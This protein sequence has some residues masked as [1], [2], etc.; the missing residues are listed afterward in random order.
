MPFVA[1][2]ETVLSL[3]GRFD[4]EA[5][6]EVF[7]SELDDLLDF[8]LYRWKDGEYADK[9]RQQINPVPIV[10]GK[11]LS[12]LTVRANEKFSL[13]LEGTGLWLVRAQA[14]GL[15]AYAFVVRNNLGALAVEAGR[16]TLVWVQNLTD[17]RRA[18]NKRVR[19]YSLADERKIISEGRTGSD[20]AIKIPIDERADIA[21][22]GE[23]DDPAIVPLNLRNLNNNYWNWSEDFGSVPQKTLQF[24]FTDRPLYKPGDTVFFKAIVRTDDDTIYRVQ[25]G[26][27]WKAVLA[28]G[29]GE[30]KK[31]Y[32]QS[33][34]T[35]DEFGNF[36]GEFVIPADAPTG[37]Y[38]LETERETQGDSQRG[39]WFWRGGGTVYFRVEHYRKPEQTVKV[40]WGKKTAVAGQSAQIHLSGRYFSGQ[41]LA[42]ERVSYR[43]T[44]S[45]VYDPDRYEDFLHRYDNR[46]S[47]YRGGW[48]EKEVVSGE[49]VLGPDGTATVDIPVGAAVEGK[50]SLYT[51]EVNH[52]PARGEPVRDWEN[53]LVFPQKY[54]LYRTDDNFSVEVGEKV[55]LKLKL[56]PFVPGVDLSGRKFVV[57]PE[58]VW[59]ERNKT[60]SGIYDYTRREEKL[61]SFEVVSDKRGELNF[62]FSAEKEGS[63]TFSVENNDDRGFLSKDFYFWIYQTDDSGIIERG[64]LSILPTKN[65]LSPHVA[66]TFVITSE[67]PVGDVLFTLERDYAHDYR[68]VSLRKK[69]TKVSVPIGDWAVPNFNAAVRGFDGKELNV[70][71]KNVDVVSSGKRLGIEVEGIKKIYRP[72][73]KVKLKLRVVD[74]AGQPQRADLTVW[75]VDKAIFELTNRPDRDIFDRFWRYRYGFTRFG[76]SL[77]GISVEMSEGGGCFAGETPILLSDGTRKPIKD[78]KVGDKV[79]SRTSDGRRVVRTVTAVSVD[80]EDGYLL[81]NDKLRVT[82]DHLLFVNGAWR[83]ADEVRLGDKLLGEDGRSVE[84]KSLSYHRQSLPVYN[85]KVDKDFNYFAGGILAHNGKG[86]TDVRSVFKDVAYWN[87]SVRTD[88]RGEATVEFVLPDNLTTWSLSMVGNTLDTKVGETIKDLTV[89]KEYILQPV[90]PNILRDGDKPV[91]AL[92]VRNFSEKDGEFAITLTAEGAAEKTDRKVVEISA[93]EEILLE[94]PLEIKSPEGGE[95]SLH[96]E[97]FDKS[98]KRLDGVKQIIP[99]KPL[100]WYEKIS[101]AGYGS[102]TEYKLD[103]PADV[104][105]KLSRISFT[106]SP[107][108]IGSLSGAAKYLIHYPYGCMEQTVS[109]FIPALL[110]K[111]YPQVFGP[112]LAGKDLDAMVR[113]GVER[114]RKHQNTD[115][116]WSWWSGS[117]D[118]FLSAYIGDYLVR[119]R[120]LGIDVGDSLDKLRGYLERGYLV[121]DASSYASEQERIERLAGL[122]IVRDQ[123]KRRKLPPIKVSTDLPLETVA[124]AVIANVR[125]GYDDPARNGADVLGRMAQ[126]TGDS[127]SWVWSEKAR[128]NVRGD[129]SAFALRAFLLGGGERELAWRAVK[130]LRDERRREYWYNTFSTAQVLEAL[131]LFA[132]QEKESTSVAAELLDA[133]AERILQA[134]FAADASV[135]EIDLS[136]DTVRRGVSL[137]SASGKQVYGSLF[138]RLFRTDMSQA[139]LSQGLTL[140]RYYIKV[141]PQG[142]KVPETDGLRA[143]DTVRVV[144]HLR[145]LKPSYRYL[146]VRDHLPAGL[147]PVNEN[148]KNAGSS[149]SL[150]R[151]LPYGANIEYEKDGA[152]LS[153]AHPKREE[154]RFSY[155]ARVVSVGEFS[156]LPA[157]AEL[158]YQPDIKAR[159]SAARISLPNEEIRLSGGSSGLERSGKKID[160]PQK[161]ILYYSAGAVTLLL[162]FSVVFIWRKK[163]KAR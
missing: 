153:M 98:G 4:S 130:T 6:V 16:E 2:E 138:A 118:L 162:L 22:V 26:Q 150:A 117:S 106:V 127:V 32:A 134:D 145:G 21:V 132:A 116:G 9:E 102:R 25:P 39:F 13:P 85:F 65:P 78:I 141:G 91:L 101:L 121:K 96:F 154:V 10:R 151:N 12:R 79:V 50:L 81:I 123:G 122:L 37:E 17:L 82:P 110:A 72:G 55:N 15:T 87:P 144:L 48:R 74:S 73:E 125:A 52:S 59:Y 100:G 28:R 31:V 60:R 126:H 70:A 142:E 139:P 107:T 46:N 38:Y 161:K 94:W 160:N 7:S 41:P 147:V 99:V 47:F 62:D 57:R 86:S 159:T 120:N 51:V 146:V 71:D 63:Y 114:L 131:T 42:G 140:K 112:A 158:M 27:K 61:P 19:I 156:A 119:A 90:L 155:L 64:K 49:V 143:G 24:L 76:H 80:I 83:R 44:A 20:G 115:G 14:D 149:K 56:V 104:N 137:V 97:M 18:A 54:G 34:L 43:V 75:A 128:F 23:N 67:R 88:K 108:L 111:E 105:E 33:I 95:L 113:R 92:K 103:I 124:L 11:P 58:R 5:Q 77:R 45:E 129:K 1:S 93:G 152:V 3:R 66:G 148:L 68:V 53:L 36:A 69:E 35:T 84:V 8:L 135:R 89:G 109:R 40:R 29:W 163:R 133:A 136:P 157:E 30:N